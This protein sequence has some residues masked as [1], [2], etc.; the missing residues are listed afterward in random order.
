MYNFDKKEF[1]GLQF[2]DNYSFKYYQ[3]WKGYAEE[4]ELKAAETRYGKNE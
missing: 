1:E 2:P 4:S 3:E